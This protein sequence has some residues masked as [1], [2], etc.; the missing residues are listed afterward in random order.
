M[1]ESTPPGHVQF[2]KFG[3][4]LITDKTQPYA[5]SHQVIARLAA[6]VRAALDADP[7]LRLVLGHGSGSFGHWAARPY[8]TRAGVSTPAQWRGFAQ[9]SAAAARLNRIVTDAFLEAGV[10]V[11][12]L[13]PSASARCHNGEVVEMSLRPIVEALGKGLVPLVYG[14]VALDDVRGGT[15]ASTEEIFV[16]LA[17]P[18]HPSRILLF[19]RVP[20]VLDDQGEVIPHITPKTYARWRDV[21]SGPRG[22]DVTGGMA[23]KVSR[24]VELVRRHPE[25]EVRILAGTQPELL[26]RILL[27]QD[28]EGGTTI[29]HQCP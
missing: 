15:I 21:F 10:P 20:G 18:L 24:M 27:S 5:A 16:H 9:V 23:E 22:V 11:L 7:D 28:H 29:D 8:G 4:S 3:G 13:Q 26:T 2:V 25:T 14:D 1:P 12:S 19:A 6:E 17:D